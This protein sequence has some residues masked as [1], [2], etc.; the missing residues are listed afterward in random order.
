MYF[1]K[2][3]AYLKDK[4]RRQRRIVIHM[5]GLKMLFLNGHRRAYAAPPPFQEM[6]VFELCIFI[7]LNLLSH[8]HYDATNA[9][10]NEGTAHFCRMS[11]KEEEEEEEAVTQKTH[12]PQNACLFLRL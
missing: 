12:L 9:Y 6:N 2:I 11:G 8:V 4:S 3:H 1:F 5:G 10:L 7:G